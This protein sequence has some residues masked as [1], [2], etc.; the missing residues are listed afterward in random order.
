MFTLKVG[1]AEQY[2]DRAEGEN[3]IRVPFEILDGKD[4]VSEQV[5]SFPLGTPADDIKA[6]M[7]Q[8]LATYTEDHERYEA[9][10][11]RIAQEAEADETASA[12]SNI[13]IE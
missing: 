9:N 10:K 6:A 7:Q 8:A 1:T 2:R 11:E 4:V 5:H 12:I 3:R 13:T